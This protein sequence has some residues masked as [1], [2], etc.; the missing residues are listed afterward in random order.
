MFSQACV[1]HSVHGGGGR[2]LPDRDPAR[3]NPSPPSGKEWAVRIPLECILVY[4]CATGQGKISLKKSLST[5]AKELSIDL[6]K[7]LDLKS[8]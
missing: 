6:C 8:L 5:T 2:G 4:F 7:V 1:S 3:Q